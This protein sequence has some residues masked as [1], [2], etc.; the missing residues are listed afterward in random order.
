MLDQRHRWNLS[1]KPL[2]IGFLLSIALIL[3]AYSIATNHQLS[4]LA[5]IVV[6]L[7]LGIVQAIVQL[8]FFLHIGLESKPRWNLISLLFMVLVVVIVV[9][10]SIWIMQSLKYN[11][12][13]SEQ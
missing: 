3:I 12:T 7:G 8:I 2:V 13:H 4:G 1:L 9:G 5:A 10:G 6:I 11:M